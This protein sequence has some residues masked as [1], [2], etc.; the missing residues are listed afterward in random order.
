MT[1]LSLHSTTHNVPVCRRSPIHVSP[2][3]HSFMGLQQRRCS[4]PSNSTS[5]SL[6]RLPAQPPDLTT[7][8]GHCMQ[9]AGE[10]FSLLHLLLP[11]LRTPLPTS[12]PSSPA[13]RHPLGC[14]LCPRRSIWVLSRSHRFPALQFTEDQTLLLSAQLNRSSSP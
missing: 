5:A 7:R 10:L 4:S 12:C 6:P 11:R 14:L 3:A 1:S 13:A 8:R 9:A 2:L